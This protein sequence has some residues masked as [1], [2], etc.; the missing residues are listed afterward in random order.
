MKPSLLPLSLA[1]VSA[2]CAGPSP[3]AKA[4]T[5]TIR[6][7]RAS[8]SGTPRAG[9]DVFELSLEDVGLLTGHTC[10]CD[11]AG[12][13]I[14]RH[15]LETL[16]PGEIPMRG[17]LK[18]AVSDFNPDLIDAIAF[19]T[20]ARLNRGEFTGGES[21]LVV[22]RSLAGPEG[23]LTL[24]FRRKDNGRGLKAV[25]DRKVLLTPAELHTTSV[26]KAKIM[27]G[28]ASDDE[29][30]AFAQTTQDIVQRELTAQPA[31]AIVYTPI[32]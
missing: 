22:D 26:V 29:K 24:V 5:I 15:A 32:E 23:T 14:T 1:V 31:G 28:E 20:G 25:I 2:A 27:K 21:D 10:G 13:L 19:I 17:T 4:G 8:M 11:T 18:V 16:F 7:Q 3:Y 9:G 12:F 6:D 30:R